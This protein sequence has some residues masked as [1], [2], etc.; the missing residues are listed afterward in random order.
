MLKVLKRRAFTKLGLLVALLAGVV[1]SVL[2]ATVDGNLVEAWPNW[3]E[4]HHWL[5]TV[6][7]IGIFLVALTAFYAIRK[8][9]IQSSENVG[10]PENLATLHTRVRQLLLWFVCVEL[11]FGQ[12]LLPRVLELFFS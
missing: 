5:M 11:L 9:T 1:V 3:I 8:Q 6:V 2:L 10:I 12:S 4:P 7:R